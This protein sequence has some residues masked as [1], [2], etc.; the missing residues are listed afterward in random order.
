MPRALRTDVGGHIYHVLNRSN[1][2]MQIFD[3]KDDYMLFINVL[4][5]AVERFDMRLLAYCMMPN[6]WHLVLQPK[7]DGDLSTFVGWLTNTHTRRWHASKGTT[8]EGHLYQGRY[9]SF[10]CQ[11]DDN[12]LLTVLRYVERNAKKAKL[13]SRAENWKYG[14]AYLYYKGTAKQKKILSKWPIQRPKDYLI[15][16]NSAI[17]VEEE[18]VLEHSEK[19]GSP[20]GTLSWREGV[21][22]KFGLQATVRPRGRPKKGG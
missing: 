10:L 3:T 4:Q 11:N 22:E 19:R 8:G 21:V 13:V 14:S 18:E 5:E 12:H 1:A 16:L 15:L 6:H 9:K 20:Y 2:R 17:T 7:K